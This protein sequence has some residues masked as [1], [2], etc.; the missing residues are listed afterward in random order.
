MSLVATG[1]A[2]NRT[3]QVLGLA[4][5]LGLQTRVN[6]EVRQDTRTSDLLFGVRAV[7]EFVSQGTTLEKGSVILTG[8]PGGVGMGFA[9]PKW[10]R[11][12]DVVVVSIERIGAISNRMVFT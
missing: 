2:A 5:D 4:D 3:Q 11:D 8:T 12:G 9:P 1:K 10:L 6:G 7:V